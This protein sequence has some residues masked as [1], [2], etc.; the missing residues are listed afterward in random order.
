[1]KI[2]HLIKAVL[3]FFPGVAQADVLEDRLS[4][5]DRGPDGRPLL[6]R[7]ARTPLPIT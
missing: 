1:M 5:A 7:W 4:I 6:T 2:R 3:A